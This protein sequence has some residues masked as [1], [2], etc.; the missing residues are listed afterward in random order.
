MNIRLV[1]FW[2]GR[3]EGAARQYARN[4]AA[5]GRERTLK[6]RAGAGGLR[7]HEEVAGEGPSGPG[8]P[9]VV[10]VIDLFSAGSASPAERPSRGSFSSAP[11]TP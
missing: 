2:N 7:R 1:Y 6:G 8:G 5:R 9:A 4:G 3:G 10:E 11:T